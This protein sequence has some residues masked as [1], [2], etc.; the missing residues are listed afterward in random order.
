MASSASIGSCIIFVN[1]LHDDKVQEAEREMDEDRRGSDRDIS[2]GIKVK[3]ESSL[4][5][6]F[7]PLPEWNDL[8]NS[9]TE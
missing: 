4:T 1:E 8:W 3:D 9:H 6:L 2:P 7:W 5:S